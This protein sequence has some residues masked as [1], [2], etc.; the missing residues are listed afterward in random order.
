VE[1]LGAIPLLQGAARQ[2]DKGLPAPAM[3]DLFA[4]IAARLSLKISRKLQHSA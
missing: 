1:Y 2:M 4:G 3:A